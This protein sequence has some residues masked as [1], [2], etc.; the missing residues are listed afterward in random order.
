MNC[1]KK[2]QVP[3]MKNAPLFSQ[4]PETRQTPDMSHNSL[5]EEHKQPI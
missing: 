3:P 1:Q 2:S 5:I 4:R